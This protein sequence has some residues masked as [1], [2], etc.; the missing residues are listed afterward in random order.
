MNQILAF[1]KDVQIELKKVNWPTKQEL[2]KYTVVVIGFTIVLGVFLGG[3]DYFFGFLLRKL[4][5]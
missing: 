5:F 2:L 3:L 1:L 4:V